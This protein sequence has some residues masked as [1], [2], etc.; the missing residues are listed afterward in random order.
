MTANDHDAD[1]E[2]TLPR[3]SNE[4]EFESIRIENYQAT[5]NLPSRT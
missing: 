2:G 3:Q 5:K 1:K 4:A